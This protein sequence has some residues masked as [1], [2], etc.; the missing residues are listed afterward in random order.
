MRAIQIDQYGKADLL[1]IRDIPKP[2][3]KTNEVL[4]GVQYSGVNPIDLKFRSGKMQQQISKTF[5]FIPGWELAGIVDKVGDSVKRFKV[6]DAVYSMPNSMQEGS[7]AE[8][9]SI[10]ENEVAMKPET[11]SFAQA[12]AI[13]MVAGAAYTSL[14]KVGKIKPGQKILIHGAAG[15]VGFFA[16]Q[17]AKN[18][19]AYVIG[20]ASS[21]GVDLLQSL[22]VDEI[23]DYTKTDFTTVVKNVDIVLDLVG[24]ETQ[25]KSFDVI[26]KGGQLISITMPPSQEKAEGAGI[27]AV[28]VYTNPDYEML[29]EISAMIDNGKLKVNTP[30]ILPLDDAIKAHEMIEQRTAKTKIVLDVKNNN[31]Q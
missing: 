7:Y 31:F 22:G 25:L 4:V 3:F 23:I 8:Y 2:S 21:E 9:I 29:E 27:N 15:A 16:V 18:E 24:G 19:G 6:G 17:I 12:A 11:I 5:P 10:D 13:P 30:M 26:K 14:V 1:Q 28:F 20:T